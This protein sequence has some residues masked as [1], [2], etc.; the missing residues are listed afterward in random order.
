[1]IYQLSLGMSFFG[2]L[3]L[4]TTSMSSMSCLWCVVS[5]LGQVWDL[6]FP[7]CH[8]DANLGIS[9]VKTVGEVGF[10]INC[11]CC[12][13]YI[14]NIRI[15]SAMSFWLLLA[16][17]HFHLTISKGTM[18]LLVTLFYLAPSWIIEVSIC[19]VLS[20]FR[21]LVQI[22]ISHGAA[23]CICKTLLFW[24]LLLDSRPCTVFV[25]WD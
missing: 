1:M 10:L 6:W 4:I 3:F 14:L 23:Y 20:I 16:L 21:A 24:K 25:D 19:V 9:W 18:G 15:K 17:I 7:F 5:A 2:L 12:F 11:L 13:D 22:I 8:W